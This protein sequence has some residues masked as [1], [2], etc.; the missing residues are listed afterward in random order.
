M[1]FNAF[2]NTQR[3]F[4][5]YLKLNKS[6]TFHFPIYSHTTIMHI[7]YILNQLIPM[8]KL[9][10]KKSRNLFVVSAVVWRQHLNKN[11]WHL[12]LPPKYYLRF[13]S[14]VG[15]T[16]YLV[17]KKPLGDRIVEYNFS[18]CIECTLLQLILFTMFIKVTDIAD[19]MILR[20]LFAYL[21]DKGLVLVA[22]SNRLVE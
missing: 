13:I 11:W 1:C 9:I 5:T 16:L 8:T 12:H 19:A 2:L 15:Y 7:F 20:Q 18:V 6:N 4:C 14:L 22:T 10:R 21:F 17:S 3:I